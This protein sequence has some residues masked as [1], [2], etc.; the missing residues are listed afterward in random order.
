[1]TNQINQSTEALYSIPSDLPR[2]EWLRTGMA[3]IA[4]GLTIDD[5]VDWSK[6]GANFK[7]ERDVM[8]TFKNVK[9]GGGIT[10]GSLFWMAKQYG[11]QPNKLK[12]DTPK[13]SLDEV[14][15]IWHVGIDAKYDHPYILRKK[16]NPQGLKTY[17]QTAEK[18]TIC[19]HDVRGYLMVPCWSGHKLQTI[20]FIPPAEGKKLNL[21][22][23]SF[24]EGY[25]ICGEDRSQIF[26]C[27][28]IGQAW[29]AADVSGKAAVNTF[30]LGR[31]DGVVKKLKLQFPN[32]E[33]IICADAGQ[34]KAIEKTARDNKTKYVAMPEGSNKNTDINDFL[35]SQG[36]EALINLLKNKIEPPTYDPEAKKRIHQKEEAMRATEEKI[37]IYAGLKHHI[38]GIAL[39][40]HHT[41]IFGASGSFKTTFITALCIKAL[42]EDP[43]LIVHYWGF[44]VSPPY[45]QAV[46]K[47]CKELSIEDQ[48]LLF[49]TQTAEDLKNH[50]KDYLAENIRLDNVIIVLDTYKFLSADINTKNANKEAMH[51]IKAICKLG[52]AWISIWAY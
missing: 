47:I 30:G 40:A 10:Q 33:L 41:Y 13:Q 49:D 7:S 19:G 4:A 37:S 3:A 16:G 46:L 48:F 36:R 25:F 15:R 6:S 11:W 28:G 42:T 52:V 43:N 26:I 18:L 50:Y 27:E 29:S 32:T 9:V 20:Q 44:D 23:S 24:G 31:T 2:D 39:Q 22:N 14:Q 35:I 8:N 12:I 1:M 51:F 5:I 45:V 17:P 34:E 38:D 21:P